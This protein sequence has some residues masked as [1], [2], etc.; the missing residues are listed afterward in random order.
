MPVLCP[1]SSGSR[2]ARTAGEYEAVEAEEEVDEEE[3][4]AG[5][6]K[7]MT[8]D[9]GNPLAPCAGLRSSAAQ[10]FLGCGGCGVVA[11]F[12]SEVEVEGEALALV[13]ETDV[14][15]ES[16]DEGVGVCV[17]VD[18]SVVLVA[19]EDGREGDGTS[20]VGCVGSVSS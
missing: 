19:M 4:D 3:E 7:P 10:S 20:F 1:V 8:P 6:E 17:A 9:V 15:E 12:R 13:C 5:T 18:G 16:G 2:C 11:G 14:A